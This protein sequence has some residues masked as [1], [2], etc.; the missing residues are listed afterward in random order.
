[1][2]KTTQRLVGTVWNLVGENYIY[3]DMGL[4]GSLHPVAGS[5]CDDFGADIAL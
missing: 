4:L 2:A 1:M 3:L 5:G